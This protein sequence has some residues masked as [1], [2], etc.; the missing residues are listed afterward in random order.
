MSYENG[1]KG[2]R[3]GA[4]LK[5]R[6]RR[7]VVISAAGKDATFVAVARNPNT[8]LLF[9]TVHPNVSSPA[10]SFI[11]VGRSLNL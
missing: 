3:G 7:L 11:G 6:G 4:M 9:T 8:A 5:A 1:P 10:L 2:E